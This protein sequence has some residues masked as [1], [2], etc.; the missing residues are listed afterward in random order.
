[1]LL[2]FTG[3]L[4]YLGTAVVACF[5]SEW[6]MTASASTLAGT[7][8]WFHITQSSL[9]YWLD[10]IAIQW[11][12][13]QILYDA[14]RRGVLH[15]LCV[16]S[17]IGYACGVY[18]GGRRWNALAWG[19]NAELWHASIHILSAGVSACIYLFSSIQDK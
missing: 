14:S 6:W 3:A 9:A 19:P 10:Q 1:M 11:F 17:S 18:Y 15:L 4:S 8:F 12:V 7:S 16:A 2:A 13:G 5:H